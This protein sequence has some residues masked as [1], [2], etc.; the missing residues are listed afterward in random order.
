MTPP[1]FAETDLRHPSE[2]TVFVF[3]VVLNLAI[4]AGAVV[5]AAHGT[6]KLA[7]HPGLAKVV[8]HHIAASSA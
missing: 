4:M 5:F 3:S 2:W 8:G 6:E 1:S 7:A